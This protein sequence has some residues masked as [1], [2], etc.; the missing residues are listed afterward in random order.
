MTTSWGR[1]IGASS[2]ALLALTLLE[3]LP[4]GVAERRAV[5]DA[6]VDGVVQPL[7][8]AEE[9]GWALDHDPSRIDARTATRTRAA[10][11]PSRRLH[12]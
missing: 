5:A 2:A 8:D 7:G 12:R 9:L 6:A 10:N 4:L 3:E 1:T 11:E